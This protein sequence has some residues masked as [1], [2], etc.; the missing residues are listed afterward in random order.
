M[1]I[2]R[3]TPLVHFPEQTPYAEATIFENS[4]EVCLVEPLVCTSVS[5]RAVAL[6]TAD[7]DLPRLNAAVSR[8]LGREL[9]GR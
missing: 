9:D 4:N 5:E 8:L 2:R 1:T 3:P 6:A 7:V